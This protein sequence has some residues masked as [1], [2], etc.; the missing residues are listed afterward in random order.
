M[1]AP[2]EGPGYRAQHIHLLR[3]VLKPRKVLVEEPSFFQHPC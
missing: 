3:T 2:V 1:I